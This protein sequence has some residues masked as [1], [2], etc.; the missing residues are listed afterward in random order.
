ML[1][2]RFLVIHK[3]QEMLKFHYQT[4]LISGT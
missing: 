2:E 4:H 1:K 3:L